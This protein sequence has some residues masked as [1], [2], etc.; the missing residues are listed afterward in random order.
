MFFKIKLRTVLQSALSF[1]RA[2][3][4]LIFSTQI[5]YLFLLVSVSVPLHPPLFDRTDY[6]R[7]RVKIANP[8]SYKVFL[9]DPFLLPL[10]YVQIFPS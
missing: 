8:S 5:I 3:F 7:R 6:E 1:P 9:A 10:Y 2:F 4:P